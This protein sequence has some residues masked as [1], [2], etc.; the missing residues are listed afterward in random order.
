[1]SALTATKSASN[2][3]KDDEALR[4]AVQT[5]T[6]NILSQLRAGSEYDEEDDELTS[7]PTPTASP[8]PVASAIT[9][10]Q[11]GTIV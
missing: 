8:P 10:N 5:T 7:R 4:S 11:A 3:E 9:A 6:K 2:N 1:M